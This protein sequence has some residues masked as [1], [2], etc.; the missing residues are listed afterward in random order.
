VCGMGKGLIFRDV[1]RMYKS[2]NSY[3]V[4]VPPKVVMRTKFRY[5]KD[6]KLEVYP[7]KIVIRPAR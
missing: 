3:V 7:D 6:V 2:G 4:A 5:V 1:R